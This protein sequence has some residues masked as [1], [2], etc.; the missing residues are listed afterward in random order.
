ML[1]QI[2]KNHKGYKAFS[3]EF[4]RS[5]IEHLKITFILLNISL[6]NI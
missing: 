2:L 1:V 3:K 5:S 4:S 6:K